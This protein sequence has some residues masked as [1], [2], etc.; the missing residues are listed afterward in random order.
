MV[1][2]LRKFS[3]QTGVRLVIGFVLI[4]FVVGDGLIYLI[5]GPGSA[6]VGLMCL[7]GAFVPVALI[8][9]FLAIAD[10]VVKRANHE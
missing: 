4:V 10:W 7:A 3:R 8:V 9:V 6:L 2:D 5:Y 1:R